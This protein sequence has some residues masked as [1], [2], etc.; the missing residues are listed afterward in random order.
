[1]AYAM[2][3]QDDDA[4]LSALI[5]RLSPTGDPLWLRGDIVGAL[6]VLVVGLIS[7][8]LGGGRFAQSLAMVAVS[9]WWASMASR[10]SVSTVASKLSPGTTAIIRTGVAT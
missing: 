8:R 3:G 7:R 4:T 5:T 9:G 6:T 2:L 10:K 1:M